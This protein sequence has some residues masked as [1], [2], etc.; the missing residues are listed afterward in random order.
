MLEK[1]MSCEMRVIF[2][3]LAVVFLLTAIF[4]KLFAIIGLILTVFV[5]TTGTCIG[6]KILAPAFCKKSVTDAISKATDELKS[7]ADDAM[8][9][10]KDA[11]GNA[12]DAIKKKVKKD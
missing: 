7:A 11:A 3:A 12:V 6:V 8:E 9:N 10:V 4:G 1:N 5:A 2:A